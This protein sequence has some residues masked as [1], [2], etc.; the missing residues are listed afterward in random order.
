MVVFT[1]PTQEFKLGSLLML[2]NPD[3][4]APGRRFTLD[5]S[6]R[7][8]LVEK[9]PPRY[10]GEAAYTVQLGPENAHKPPTSV[11]VIVS[12]MYAPK[13]TKVGLMLQFAPASGEEQLS[14]ALL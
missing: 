2:G 1:W 13:S 4:T 5:A 7:V 3:G 11:T 14:F 10:E 6:N 9:T 8:L 12:P